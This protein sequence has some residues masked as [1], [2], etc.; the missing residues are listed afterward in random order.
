MLKLSPQFSKPP[1]IYGLPKLHKLNTPLR[2]IDSSINCPTYNL[3]TFI[4]PILN[5]LFGHSKSYITNA[6]HSIANIRT[7][8]INP[9]DISW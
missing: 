3:S 4:W 1:H 5:S 6:Q 9:T 2:P 8:T 7:T